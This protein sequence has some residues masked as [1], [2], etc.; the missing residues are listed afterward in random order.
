MHNS[1][2]EKKK[3]IV[4]TSLNSVYVDIFIRSRV[5]VFKEEEHYA[6]SYNS[7]VK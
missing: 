7:S 3:K 1:C 2:W 6:K 5:L 4:K